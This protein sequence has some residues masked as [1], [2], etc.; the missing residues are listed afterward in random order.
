MRSTPSLLALAVGLAACAPPAEPERSPAASP[1]LRLVTW[2]VHDLFDAVDRTAA[3]G[4]EDTVLSPA[5][6]A[7]KL[8][9]VGAVLARLDADVLLLEEVEDEELLQRLA[10]GALAGRGYRAFLREGRDPRGIDVGVLSRVPFEVGPSHLDERAADG[11]F[12]WARDVLEVRLRLGGR[13]LTVLGAHLVS[14]RD[15]G[16]D[17]RRLEQAERLRALAA[18]AARGEPGPAV[19]VM[20]DLNDVPG[21]PPIAALLRGGA[22]EDTGAA[23]PAA[24]SWTWSGGGARE[25]LDYALLWAAGAPRVLRVAVEAG[26]DVSAA[27]DHRPLAVELWDA[28]AGSLGGGE[29]TS[30]P[31]LR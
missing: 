2:N 1:A 15:P 26:P 21:S 8:E 7:R 22:L 25:R 18:A 10:A 5:E 23:L 3:P 17:G 14:R 24:A 9:R 13:P 30:P 16:E 20:G 6:A 12:L 28:G 29:Q 19:L 11:R 31:P 27:S 4:A